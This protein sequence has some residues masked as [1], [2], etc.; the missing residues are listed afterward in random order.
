MSK[1][2]YGIGYNSRRKH[3][4]CT[5][6]KNTKVYQTWCDMMKRSYCKIYQDKY[7]TYVGCEVS[8]EWHDFQDFADWFEQKP[9]NDCG[10]HLDKD[11]L[12]NNNKMY[13]PDTCC[14]IPHELNLLIL[15]RLPSKSGLP[16]GV[17][18]HKRD[19]KFTSR[20]RV[21]GKLNHMG[22]FNCPNEAHQVYKTAKERHI[23]NEAL[24]WANRIEWS[25]F[26]ALMNWTL[27]G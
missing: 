15:N 17:S 13:S 18:F 4:S 20:L 7:P 19:L 23:K 2:F 9:Y 11:V 10:Y 12:M 24:K 16:Q 25:V 8:D 6:G 21:N 22:Y 14:F 3:E 26:V 27:D 5:N 1:S